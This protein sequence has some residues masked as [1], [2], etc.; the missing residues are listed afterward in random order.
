M[1]SFVP[2]VIVP[3]VVILNEYVYVV[4]HVTL[5]PIEAEREQPH[6]ATLMLFND[7]LVPTLDDLA[8]DSIAPWFHTEPLD[9]SSVGGSEDKTSDEDHEGEDSKDHDSGDNDNDRVRQSVQTRTFSTPYMYRAASLM[10]AAPSTSYARPVAHERRSSGHVAQ[11]NNPHKNAA[12]LREIYDLDVR[13]GDTD[14]DPFCAEPQ[15]EA[16]T[17]CLT[18]MTKRWTLTCKTET[19]CA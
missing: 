12:S 1:Y 13:G 4:I 11:S 6:I 16:T 14:P 5:R 8:R 15:E 9:S 7:P 18:T 17:H 3:Y 10:Q 19:I 2:F